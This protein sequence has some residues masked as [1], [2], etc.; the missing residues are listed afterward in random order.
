MAHGVAGSRDAYCEGSTN[1]G[2]LDRPRTTGGTG[3][4][5]SLERLFFFVQR[6]FEERHGQRRKAGLKKNVPCD[7]FGVAP[8]HRSNRH[9]TYAYYYTLGP[10]FKGVFFFLR[11]KWARKRVFSRFFTISAEVFPAP[12]HSEPCFPTNHL[13]AVDKLFDRS[14]TLL[15][16][17][18]CDVKRGKPA[19]SHGPV[20]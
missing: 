9:G 16:V 5:E 3:A 1:L 6:E 8:I 14:Q 20:P 18:T 13:P 17:R 11:K 4:A 15:A 7:H 10:G 12:P 2:R 19:P